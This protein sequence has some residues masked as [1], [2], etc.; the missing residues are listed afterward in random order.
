MKKEELIRIVK[1]TF[2]S[3]SDGVIELLS[4]MLLYD[5]FKVP[6]WISYLTAL[7][8]SVLWNFT[9]NRKFTFKSSNN[10]PIAMLKV[11]FFY[12]IFTPAS[13]YFGHVLESNGLNGDVVT[14]INMLINFVLEFLYQK[15]YVFNDK[16]EKHENN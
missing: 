5:V 16:K 9:L 3:I 6:Y 14:I 7:T 15:Y 4:S 12:L 1:F 2:F 11:F 10:V 13:T 8:L